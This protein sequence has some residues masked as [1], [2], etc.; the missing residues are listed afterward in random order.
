MFLY[1]HLQEQMKEHPDL[2]QTAGE[3]T[4]FYGKVLENVRSRANRLRRFAR[5]VYMCS[6][7]QLQAEG[8]NVPVDYRLMLASIFLFF[9]FMGFIETQLGP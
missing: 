2:P 7:Q 9:S 1:K 8:M 3:V 6:G 4:K 5:Q